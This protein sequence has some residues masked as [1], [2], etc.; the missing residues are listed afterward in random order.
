MEGNGSPGSTGVD[1]QGRLLERRPAP[2]DN[3]KKKLS[4]ERYRVRKPS[5][6]KNLLHQERL[7]LYRKEIPPERMAGGEIS[8]GGRSLLQGL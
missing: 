4:P 7:R 5:L 8:W 3:K 2:E 1:C 6:S